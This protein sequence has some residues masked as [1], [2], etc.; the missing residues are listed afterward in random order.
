MIRSLAFFLWQDL[1]SKELWKVI[2][3]TARKIEAEDG[4]LIFDNTIQEKR[5]SNVTLC[6]NPMRVFKFKKKTQ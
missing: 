5:H 3:K 4:V 2:Q 1:T 6:D